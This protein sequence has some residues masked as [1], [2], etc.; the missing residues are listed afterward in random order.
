MTVLLLDEA[1]VLLAEREKKDIER[2]AI[3]SSKSTL[4][5]LFLLN[6][7]GSPFIRGRLY[8]LN[9]LFLLTLYNSVS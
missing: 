9:V 3:V 6:M 2:N 5:R 7:H 1:D 4:F 8:L